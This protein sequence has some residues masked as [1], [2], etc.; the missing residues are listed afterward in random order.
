[1]PIIAITATGSVNLSRAVQIGADFAY[2]KPFDFEKIVGEIGE[3]V[4]IRRRAKD[5]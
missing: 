2:L 1:M 5:L 3:L 4:A